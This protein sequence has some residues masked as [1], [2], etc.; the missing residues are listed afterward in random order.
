MGE[1][2]VVWCD[3][4]VCAPDGPRQ[5]RYDNCYQV[6]TVIKYTGLLPVCVFPMGLSPV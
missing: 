2:L 5:Q 3:G 1:G 6:N 4:R